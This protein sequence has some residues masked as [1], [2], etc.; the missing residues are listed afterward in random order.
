MSVLGGGKDRQWLEPLDEEGYRRT[1]E[2]SL[3]GMVGTHTGA[4][5]GLNLLAP[6]EGMEYVWE[7]NNPADILRAR[8][9]GGQVV[10]AEDPERSVMREATDVDY[11]PLDSAEIYKDVVLVRY[12]AEAVRRRREHIQ[13]KSEALQRG[14]ARDFADRATSMERELAQGLPT[15]FRRADHRVDFTDAEGQLV[16]QWTP[17]SGIIDKG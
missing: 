12:P 13:Q 8:Q 16:D 6:Q 10:A 14:G 17:E 3:D 2:P 5:V 9:Q 1:D 7:R 11:T 4:H 15:R